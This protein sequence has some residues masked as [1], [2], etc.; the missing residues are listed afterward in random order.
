MV[1]GVGTPNNQRKTLKGGISDIVD[2]EEGVE[3]ASLAFMAEFNVG[4]VIGDGALGLGF[5]EHLPSGHIDKLCIGVDEAANE[6]GTRNAIDFRLLAR[7]PF[8]RVGRKLSARR[9]PLCE[10][11]SEAAIKIVR[12]FAEIA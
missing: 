2:A 1:G 10:P 3:R 5:L 7:D 11:T 4:N 6:P 8:L 9:K 12:V